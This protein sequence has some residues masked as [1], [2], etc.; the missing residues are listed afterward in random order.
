M[1]INFL[2]ILEG[3]VYKWTFFL[4]SSPAAAFC[5]RTCFLRCPLCSVCLR[6]PHCT[7]LKS[8]GY[9]INTRA[10]QWNISSNIF[11]PIR[12]AGFLL[13][14]KS[15]CP[16]PRHLLCDLWSHQMLICKSLSCDDIHWNRSTDLWFKYFNTTVNL[17]S[18]GV[19]HCTDVCLLAVRDHW[20]LHVVYGIRFMDLIPC[21][22][23]TPV[24]VDIFISL[25][26]AFNPNN[27]EKPLW[28]VLQYYCEPCQCVC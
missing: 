6:G 1:W 5:Q 12:A 14:P 4:I 15:L 8:D 19:C 11:I 2:S 9:K 23:F 22:A 21:T 27:V 10:L 3:I 16:P 28:A 24:F 18:S 20:T 7:V 26:G 13:P 17:A 25:W